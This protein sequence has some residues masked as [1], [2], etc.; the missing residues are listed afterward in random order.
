MR[1]LNSIAPLFI[2]SFSLHF[3]TVDT[4][5]QAVFSGKMTVEEF[6]DKWAEAMGDA[7]G[8]LR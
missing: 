4:R 3:E 8:T 6:L 5:T 7:Q 2:L 1:L